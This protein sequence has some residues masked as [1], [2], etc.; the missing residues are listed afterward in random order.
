MPSEIP[1][2]NMAVELGRNFASGKK[3]ALL[4]EKLDLSDPKDNKYRL[5]LQVDFLADVVTEDEPADPGAANYASFPVH[6]STIAMTTLGNMRFRGTGS[7]IFLDFTDL[8]SFTTN[9]SKVRSG[10]PAF[11]EILEVLPGLSIEEKM[12]LKSLL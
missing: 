4:M 8:T 11:A 9:G 1:A 7:T 12:Q 6:P 3:V 10:G 5:Y 2:F